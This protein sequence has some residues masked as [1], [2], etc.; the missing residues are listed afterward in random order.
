M[1]LDEPIANL[2]VKAQDKFLTD[3]QRIVTQQSFKTSVVL[4]SQQLYQ[5]EAFSDNIVFI[6]DG[7][8]EYS[9]KV[10]AVGQDRHNNSFEIT[11]NV[12]ELELMEIFGQDIQ[13]ITAKGKIIHMDTTIGLSSQRLMQELLAKGVEISYFRDISSS[14][15]KMFR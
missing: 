10:E 1:V 2:D 12:G 4:S 8:I 13:Q 7:N 11:C 3:L 6:K 15:K 5:V 9:G 14:T